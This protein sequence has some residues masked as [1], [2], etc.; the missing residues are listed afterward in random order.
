MKDTSDDYLQRMLDEGNREAWER[1]QQ[2][3][4]SD[5]LEAYKQLYQMLEKELPQGL[6]MN[7]SAKVI[8]Q[9]R[10]RKQRREN[11]VLAL[12]MAGAILLCLLCAVPLMFLIDKKYNSLLLDALIQYKWIISGSLLSLFFIQYFDHLFIKS[13]DFSTGQK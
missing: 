8:G 10:L 7:F 12:S 11:R 4:D 13:K 9:V 3:P 2:T 5:E 1:P 6:P